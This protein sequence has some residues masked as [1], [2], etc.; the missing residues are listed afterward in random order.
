MPQKKESVMKGFLS[1]IIILI[2]MVESALYGAAIPQLHACVTPKN[3]SPEKKQQLEEKSSAQIIKKQLI[4]IEEYI[5]LVNKRLSSIPYDQ[6]TKGEIQWQM[7]KDIIKEVVLKGIH[8]D[9]IIPDIHSRWERPA[10]LEAIH[11]HT[12]DTRGPDNKPKPGNELDFVQFLLQH[13]ADH[14]SSLEYRYSILQ[15]VKTIGMADLLIQHGAH[16]IFK[17]TQTDFGVA[18]LIYAIKHTYKKSASP[19]VAL[20]I[21]HGANVNGLFAGETPLMALLQVSTEREPL[22]TAYLLMQAGARLNIVS[23][24]YGLTVPQKIKKLLHKE[25]ISTTAK[26]HLYLLQA[27]LRKLSK[28]FIEQKRL[29]EPSY[30][31]LEEEKSPAL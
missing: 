18:S 30:K 23:P 16:E 17:D 6:Q 29:N 8:P 12:T 19:L 7:R 9:D 31:E 22:K 24:K 2:F 26:D 13:K 5:V 10:L 4:T 3:F 1:L 25:T 11:K 28:T 27:L 20:Y 21:K 15:K 14:R